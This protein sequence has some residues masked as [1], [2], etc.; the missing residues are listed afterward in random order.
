MPDHDLNLVACEH[1]TGLLVRYLDACVF[2][3]TRD[4]V[5]EDVECRKFPPNNK[6]VAALAHWVNQRPPDVL[7]TR[8]PERWPDLFTELLAI[9]DRH[10]NAVWARDYATVERARGDAKATARLIAAA[11]HRAAASCHRPSVIIGRLPWPPTKCEDG[12][13][14]NITLEIG[15]GFTTVNTYF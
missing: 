1:V 2:R 5:L 3:V 14:L 9:R 6:G 15:Q 11:V 7:V 12:H 4:G 13:G 8:F 10:F